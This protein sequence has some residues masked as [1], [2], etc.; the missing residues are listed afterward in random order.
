MVKKLGFSWRVES[1]SR[2]PKAHSWLH[3]DYQ[4]KVL[5]HLPPLSRNLLKGEFLRSK[6]LGARVRRLGPQQWKAHPPMSHDFLIPLNIKFCSIWCRLAGTA[7][8][9]YGL[10]FN[11]L[12]GFRV[13][14]VGRKTVPIKMLTAHSNSLHILRLFCTVWPQYT[15]WQTDRQTER[16]E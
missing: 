1:S 9:N 7:M 14:L 6:I 11:S 4:F 3:N 15:M 5:L 10:Q 12:S 16:S 8:S 2:Q 13:D